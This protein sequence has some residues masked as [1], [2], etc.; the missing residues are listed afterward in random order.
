MYVVIV[1]FK[2]QSRPITSLLDAG[3]D[4]KPYLRKGDVWVKEDTRLK[5]AMRSDFDQMYESK[6]QEEGAKRARLIFD[7]LKSELG[8]NFFPK[9]LLLPLQWNSSLVLVHG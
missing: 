1:L 5:L 2:E 7:H 6:I 4:E 3:T 8:Q 9:Q